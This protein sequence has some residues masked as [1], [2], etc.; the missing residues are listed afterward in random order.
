MEDIEDL[1]LWDTNEDILSIF[2][3]VRTFLGENYEF[4]ENILLRLIDSKKL[5]LE[6]SLDRISYIHS[7]YVGVLMA[8]RLA[9]IGNDNNE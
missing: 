9:S 8:Q 1:Y 5:N 6:D 7:G 3:S 4:P 2:K